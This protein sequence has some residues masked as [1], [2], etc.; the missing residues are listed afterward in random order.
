MRYNK[1]EE[2][3]IYALNKI[4]HAFR[5]KEPKTLSLREH[6]ALAE[7]FGINIKSLSL[8]KSKVKKLVRGKEDH[9]L[10]VEPGRSPGSWHPNTFCFFPFQVKEKKTPRHLT[11]GSTNDPPTASS[12]RA[13][14]SNPAGV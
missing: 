9:L 12:E 14:K 10:E 13:K 6:N 1:R 7:V 11:S 3:A 8:P 5:D 2:E 4:A